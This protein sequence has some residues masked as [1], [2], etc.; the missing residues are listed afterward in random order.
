MYR[1]E[2][3]EVNFEQILERVRAFLSKFRLGG[4]GGA[5]GFIVIGAL[6][7]AAVVW[8]GTGV[9]SVQPGEQAALR[10]V[11]KFHSTTEAGLH[12]F[13]PAPIGTR[14]IVAVDT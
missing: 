6:I 13:W 3:P 2:E 7:V 5:I 4:G 10:L 9:Y 12:W 11:G 8:L 1:Q 14:A